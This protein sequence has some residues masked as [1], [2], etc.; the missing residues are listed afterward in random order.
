MAWPASGSA[1]L[2]SLASSAVALAGDTKVK[3][4]C[5]GKEMQ[6]KQTTEALEV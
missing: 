2:Q 1:L 3:L 5:S 6:W 4:M